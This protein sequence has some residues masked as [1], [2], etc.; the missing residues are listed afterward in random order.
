MVV[1][2]DHRRPTP[3]TNPELYSDSVTSLCKIKIK[4]QRW[5]L[6]PTTP[7][8]IFDE[9]WTRLR[10]GGLTS[11]KMRIQ[12]WWSNPT[13]TIQHPLQTLNCTQTRWPHFKKTSKIIRAKTKSHT[14]SSDNIPWFGLYCLVVLVVSC[15]FLCQLFGTTIDGLQLI[16]LASNTYGSNLTWSGVWPN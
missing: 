6:D 1:G 10:L 16:G 5:W 7:S 14:S 15:S 3:F 13:T 9:L 4:I 12:R 2:P 8:N 11:N